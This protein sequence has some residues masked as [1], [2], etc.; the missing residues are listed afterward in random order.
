ME[1]ILKI[2]DAQLH[3][4]PTFAQSEKLKAIR[5]NIRKP[6]EDDPLALIYKVVYARALQVPNEPV[7]ERPVGAFL[8]D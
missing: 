3:F 2:D 6:G 4:I 5:H 8:G 1:R 7:L